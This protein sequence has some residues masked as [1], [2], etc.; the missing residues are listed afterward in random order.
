[1]IPFLQQGRC[2]FDKSK[3]KATVSG[4]VDIEQG[5]ESK[6]QAAVASAGPVSVAIDASQRSFQSYRGGMKNVL[7]PNFSSTVG[8][9]VGQK[10]KLGLEMSTPET[11]YLIKG[12]SISYFN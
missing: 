1:M 9:V 3:V 12:T 6:L 4:H 10:H 2:K 11:G 7:L 5:S 8:L